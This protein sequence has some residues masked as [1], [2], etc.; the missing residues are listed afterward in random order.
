MHQWT[1]L[2]MTD[3]K[4]SRHPMRTS[5]ALSTLIA[6]ALAAISLTDATDM[7][8]HADETGAVK[9][10]VGRWYTE[11]RKG[12][13]GER[14]DAWTLLAPGGM[15]EPSHRCYDPDIPQ[16]RV[17]KMRGPA[18]SHLLAVRSQKFTHEIEKLQV[19]RTLARID[20][21]E[22]GWIYA[23]ATKSTYENAAGATFILE[24]KDGQDWK[25]LLYASRSS[26]VRPQ[27]RDD[28]MPDLSP[29]DGARPL[30]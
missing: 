23:G 29:K 15:I 26:A 7:P 13:L 30:E 24:K 20:V 4:L 28:P 18:Y 2:E 9:Q 22:R 10:L 17:L 21:W 19:E 27:D 5:R 8:A 14:R 12:R 25:I 16:P 6:F 11:L 3:C 1:R